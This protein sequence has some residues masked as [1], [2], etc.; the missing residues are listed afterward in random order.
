MR[1]EVW[2]RALI[3][4]LVAIACVRNAAAHS[5]PFSYIDL[6][7][8]ADRIDGSVVVHIYDAAHDLSIA[9]QER[10]LDPAFLQTQR[11]ALCA[12]LSPRLGI[13]AAGRLLLPE[14]TG[15][16]AVPAQQGVRLRFG[17]PAARPGSL[18]LHP[19]T[20]RGS[21]WIAPVERGSRYWAPTSR[22]AS[23]AI[24]RCR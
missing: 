1:L 22:P 23:R 8:R 19:S 18:I 17:L 12:L 13:K 2:R 11:V 9:P 7:L 14:W 16:E 5:A 20:P 6:V 10:L 3:C 24:S 21:S 4:I 15:A